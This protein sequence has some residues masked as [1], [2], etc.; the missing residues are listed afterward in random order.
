MTKSERKI[1]SDLMSCI[2]TNWA[3][4]LLTGDQKVLHGE[5]DCRDIE[6]LLIAIRRRMEQKIGMAPE[7][8]A[9]D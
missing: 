5:F 3:D 8:Q 7:Q 2:P 1:A 9:N 6:R 4:P